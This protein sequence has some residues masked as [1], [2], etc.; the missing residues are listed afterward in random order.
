MAGYDT[1]Q[2]KAQLI[3]GVFNGQDQG[4]VCVCAN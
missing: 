2:G 3:N 1:M 4:C